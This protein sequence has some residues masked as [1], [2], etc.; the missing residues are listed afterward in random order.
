M[1]GTGRLLPSLLLV[2][3]GCGSGGASDTDAAAADAA[4]LPDAAPPADAA[5]PGPDAAPQPDAMPLPPGATCQL[6]VELSPGDTYAGDTTG[7][8]NSA[9]GSCA[10]GSI[11][12]GDA[13]HVFELG[14]TPLDLVLD[15][16]VDETAEPPFDVVLHARATCSQ[17]ATELGCANAGWSEHLELLEVSGT[18]YVAVDGT[19]QH[20]GARTGPYELSSA[21]RAILAANAACTPGDPAARCAGGHRCVAQVC[22]EDSAALACGQATDVSAALAGGEVELSGTTYAYGGDFY[23]GGC[24]HD[25]GGG[26]AE[27]VVMFS[28]AETVRFEASTDFSETTF[29][30]VLYLRDGACDGAEIACHDDVDLPGNNLRS[31]LIV[32]A[33]PAGTYYLIIDGSSASPGYGAYRLRL[34]L[35]DP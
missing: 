15:V 31:H 33:L 14:D 10:A 21:S 25:P 23:Q 11:E 5:P 9:G 7:L 18:V 26:F 13:L 30:T 24:A 12:A 3:L 1:A 32:P 22:V 20:G 35:G 16:A 8:P 28:V 19:H 6:A 2:A 27:D 17:A 34:T 4:P 29:D